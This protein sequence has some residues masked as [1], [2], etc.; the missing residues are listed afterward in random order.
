MAK[1]WD[2]FDRRFRPLDLETNFIF[3]C[4]A[5]QIL[6]FILTQKSTNTSPIISGAL[7]LRNVRPINRKYFAFAGAITNNV[8]SRILC[9][10]QD[11]V[12]STISQIPEEK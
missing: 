6:N 1:E 7:F 10:Y 2:K 5:Y 4:W 8:N 12:N 9:L 11:F 3:K